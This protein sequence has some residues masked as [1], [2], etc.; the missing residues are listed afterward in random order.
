V[1]WRRIFTGI[2]WNLENRWIFDRFW[3]VA[4]VFIARG[5]IKNILKV[6]AHLAETSLFVL[7]AESQSKSKD[8]E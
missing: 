5:D 3:A 7:V 4:S 2:G 6:V 8:S 1:L